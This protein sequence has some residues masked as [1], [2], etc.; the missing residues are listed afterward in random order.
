MGD[1]LLL[2]AAKKD[3]RKYV[4]LWFNG[5]RVGKKCAVRVRVENDGTVKASMVSAVKNLLVAMPVSYRL[6]RSYGRRKYL[7]VEEDDERVRKAIE[8]AVATGSSTLKVKVR[9]IMFSVE[10][11]Q[12]SRE[13][14]R[15]EIKHMR[16]VDFENYNVD[17]LI[18]EY[19]VAVEVDGLHHYEER[20]Q[21]KDLKKLEFLKEKGYHVIRVQASDVRK[22]PAYVAGMIR[23][24]CLKLAEAGQQSIEGVDQ[25]TM[26]TWRM[27]A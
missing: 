16:N 8:R 11:L 27:K 7:L 3:G 14:Q 10:E 21:V 18:P 22:D 20:V 25:S 26:E 13:L 19:R 4:T 1:K 15:L 2:K 12:L 6:Y 17:I 9:N 23:D 5:R 24:C